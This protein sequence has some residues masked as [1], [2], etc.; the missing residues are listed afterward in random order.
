MNHDLLTSAN[1]WEGGGHL[2]AGNMEVELAPLG[3]CGP[4][5]IFRTSGSTGE[6]KWIVLEKQAMRVSARAVNAWLKVTKESRWGLA[7]P[8]N[9]VGGFSIFARCFEAGCEL[10]VFSQ[11]WDPVVFAEWVRF[12]GVTYVS[13]VPT[14]VHDLV[15]AGMEAPKS[16]TAVVVGGGRLSDDLGQAAR[17]LGWPVLASYGMTEAGSQIATQALESLK[18]DFKQARMELLP[19]WEASADEDDQLRVTGD[20]LFAGWIEANQFVPRP[21]DDFVTNDRVKISGRTIEPLGRSDSMVKVLGELVDVEAVERR[22]AGHLAASDPVSRVAVVA[23]PEGRS[24][25][26]LVA[27]FEPKADPEAVEA[28]NRQVSGPERICKFLEIEKIPRSSLGK[29][30]RRRL[31]EQVAESCR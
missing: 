4:S 2:V 17:D 22:V 15:S 7:L 8:T 28:Y 5:V 3:V 6:G 23:L 29:V 18:M 12:E 14:Q 10:S 9:H 16:L 1:F 25:H 21:S 20:A 11:P 27:V 19:I 31:A 24:E 26:V 30:L 13:L